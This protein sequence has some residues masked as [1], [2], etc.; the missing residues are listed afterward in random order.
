MIFI[1]CH[2]ADNYFWKVLL[3]IKIAS[4][5]DEKDAISESVADDVF[6]AKKS[7]IMQRPQV[8]EVKGTDAGNNIQIVGKGIPNSEVVVFIHSEQVLVYRLKVNEDG[9]WTLES[10]TEFCGTG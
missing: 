1:K 3:Y 10:F 8:I 9:G 5:N 4:E 7:M 2:A 6:Q